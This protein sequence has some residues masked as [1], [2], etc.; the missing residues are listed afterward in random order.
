MF[1]KQK[2]NSQ[3]KTVL[4]L[5]VKDIDYLHMSKHLNLLKQ[6]LII[7]IIIILNGCDLDPTEHVK[8]L[9]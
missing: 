1:T 9:G 6:G 3:E 8:Y 7:I 5:E 2:M 4:N